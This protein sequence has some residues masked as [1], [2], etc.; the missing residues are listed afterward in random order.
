MKSLLF[1]VA[2][3]SAF[4]LGGC[5]QPTSEAP[6]AE[7]NTLNIDNAWI[8]EAPPGMQMMA[9]YFKAT[10]SSDKEIAIVSATSPAFG[11]IEMH[12][13][14]VI[15]GTARMIEQ[16]TVV[17]PAQG[18]LEMKPGSYHLMLMMP[19]APLKAG[20]QVKL[21]LMMDDGSAHEVAYEVRKQEH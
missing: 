20:E 2:A 9:G 11:S 3:L 12:K 13:T 14:E 8:R 1:L 10:N 6:T 18:S 7:V 17:I 5:D 16:K 15:D 21:T 19:T 4:A